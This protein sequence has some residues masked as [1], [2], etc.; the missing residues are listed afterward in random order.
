MSVANVAD[1]IADAIEQ[2]LESVEEG[3]LKALG[4]LID[5]QRLALE[6]NGFSSF[7]HFEPSG[8]KGCWI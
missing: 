7:G 1:S 2:V 3:Q 5:L 4:Q 8:R 6:R